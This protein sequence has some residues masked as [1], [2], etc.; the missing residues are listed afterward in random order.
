MVNKF[1]LE[2]RIR[3]K[4]DYSQSTGFI[5]DTNQFYC[6]NHTRFSFVDENK[7]N[8][9]KFFEFTD[10]EEN[11]VYSVTFG[12][13]RIG[14]R[15]TVETREENVTTKDRISIFR[16]SLS[17]AVNGYRNFKKYFASEICPESIE[18]QFA[19]RAQSLLLCLYGFF[20]E[21]NIKQQN[22]FL[23]RMKS[24]LKEYTSDVKF[25][26]TDEKLFDPSDKKEIR[27]LS[28]EELKKLSGFDFGV[29]LVVCGEI[30]LFVDHHLFGTQFI[31]EDPSLSL[32]TV[33][34][35][36]FISSLKLQDLHYEIKDYTSRIERLKTNLKETGKSLIPR[37]LDLRREDL[38][39]LEKSQ[40][41]IE[42]D[43]KEF[44]NL[45]KKIYDGVEKNKHSKEVWGVMETMES[46]PH[47]LFYAYG[48]LK[49]E[50]LSRFSG[51]RRSLQDLSYDLKKL[52]AKFKKSE[53]Y[54]T[55]LTLL[56]LLI[57]V[58]AI[59]YVLN[60][61]IGYIANIFQILTFGIAF[62]LLA[63]RFWPKR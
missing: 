23:K 9:I 36:G 42:N 2:G 54:T 63:L 8:R 7:S 27:A 49:M 13:D 52:E 18:I 26:L 43:L 10:E 29:I 17:R 31:L 21:L 35:W 37:G 28:M 33:A 5:A 46:L 41:T 4:L 50:Q 38:I 58:P 47:S 22:N 34:K 3:A 60:V 11:V 51:F 20:E 12:Y 53:L 59:V 44:T 30:Y 16:S 14:L 24:E 32:M 45:S 55:V 15:F 40:A 39:D 1:V 62:I 61:D 57:A 56:T 6:D 48:I 25:L 19:P